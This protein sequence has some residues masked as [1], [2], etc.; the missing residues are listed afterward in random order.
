MPSDMIMNRETKYEDQFIDSIS[1]RLFD[2]I[3]NGQGIFISY[4]KMKILLKVHQESQVRNLERFDP[5]NFGCGEHPPKYTFSGEFGRVLNQLS[6]TSKDVNKKLNQDNLF[7]SP[8]FT[9]LTLD[10]LKP[11]I[12]SQK[13]AIE[14]LSAV[15]TDNRHLQNII[16][17][18][19][20]S[21]YFTLPRM[22]ILEKALIAHAKGDYELSVPAF[23]AQIEG[24]LSKILGVEGHGSIRNEIRK[25]FSKISADE[26]SK[27]DFIISGKEIFID[28][29]C[30]QIFKSY[31]EEKHPEKIIFKYPNR[32]RV[33]H[34]L[35]L[36]YFENSDYSTRCILILDYLRSKDILELMKNNMST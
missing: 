30:E 25:Y 6:Q 16:S 23:L 10:I 33:L 13:S 14:I 3:G 27:D 7:F 15:L 17:Q 32:H 2:E 34:G 12:D 8:Y 21:I 18:W 35:E 28:V 22:R 20:K 31:N 11:F 19:S 29:I 36:T 4:E 9:E 26:L 5:K 24:I 1:R